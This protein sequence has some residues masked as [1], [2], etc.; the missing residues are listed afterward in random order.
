MATEITK[1]TVLQYNGQEFDLDALEANVTKS[2]EEGDNGT[3]EIKTLTIYVKPED[4]KAYYVVN[5]EF[6]ANIDL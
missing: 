6:E 2:W 1:R 5:D 4:A 3:V